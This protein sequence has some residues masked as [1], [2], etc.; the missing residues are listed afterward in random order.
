MMYRKNVF[1]TFSGK[2]SFLGCQFLLIMFLSKFASMEALGAYSLGLA[3][4]APIFLFCNLQLRVMLATEAN[5]IGRFYTYFSLRFVLAL[6]AFPIA[7]I[8]V[9]GM[10]LEI[11][12]LSIVLLCTLS[13][14]FDAISDIYY[15]VMQGSNRMDLIAKSQIFRGIGSVVAFCLVF[16]FTNN[17]FWALSSIS[18]VWLLIL[19]YFDYRN[20]LILGVIK[21]KNIETFYQLLSLLRRNKSSDEKHENKELYS[22]H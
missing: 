9:L 5:V 16:F 12:I 1:W 21:S 13:K 4:S 18:V 2:I 14:F 3:I 10:G 19:I 15:G 22:Y 11:G 8:V 7:L 6:L 20:V 17:I